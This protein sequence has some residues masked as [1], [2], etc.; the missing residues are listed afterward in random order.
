LHWLLQMTPA[1][2]ASTYHGTP[3]P[4]TKR[5]G[6]A[7]NAAIALGNIGSDA[8]IPVLFAAASGHDEPL[9]RAHAAW[10][11]GR[12][13]ARNELTT[14]LSTESD[15]LVREEIAR[16]IAEPQGTIAGRFAIGETGEPHGT[17]TATHF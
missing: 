13:S 5:R 10:A 16:A 1:E 2:F 7:R 3:V 4:R 11:L 6:L 8:D 15:P 12:F 17:S 9:V 14:L